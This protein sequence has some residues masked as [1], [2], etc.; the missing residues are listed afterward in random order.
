[1]TERVQKKNDRNNQE[2]GLKDRFNRK[3]DGKKYR[4]VEVYGSII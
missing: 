1:M 4:R 2:T 3:N